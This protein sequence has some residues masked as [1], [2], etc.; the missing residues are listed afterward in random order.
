M[1]VVKNPPS[2]LEAFLG[3]IERIIEVSQKGGEP[4]G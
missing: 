1:V 4:H 3:L 2:P